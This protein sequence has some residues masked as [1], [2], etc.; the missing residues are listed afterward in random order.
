M[1]LLQH[2]AIQL[3]FT[4]NTIGGQNMWTHYKT[5]IEGPSGMIRL[6]SALA[7]NSWWKSLGNSNLEIGI[8]GDK[9]SPQLL[10]IIIAGSSGWDWY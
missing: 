10:I 1:V 8:T 7:I 2:C 5:V 6:H 9:S 3:S 4:R